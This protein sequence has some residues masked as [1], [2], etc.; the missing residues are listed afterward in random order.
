[1]NAAAP[2]LAEGQRALWER[3]RVFDVDGGQ[4]RALSFMDRLARE[5]GWSMARAR[6]VFDEY[7]RFLVL[8]MVARHPVT[9]SE[10][11]D[12][13]WHLHLVYTRSYWEDLCRD[14]LG[15][16]LHH[17]PS[18]GGS[19]EGTKMR[20]QYDDTLASYAR[21]FGA[22]PPADVWP[23]AERRFGR[24][25]RWRRVGLAGAWV[26]PKRPALAF[27]TLL[28]ALGALLWMAGGV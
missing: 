3:L 18:R 17:A 14:I 8:A 12:Q 4:P 1:M 22:P 5:N 13:A 20:A 23:R 15:C 24:D 7:R 28:A 2:A 26:I 9:P 21:V 16:P 25:L 11:V 19:D 10:D 27:A 6:R